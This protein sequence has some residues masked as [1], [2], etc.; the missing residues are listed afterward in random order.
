MESLVLQ[1]IDHCKRIAPIM[2]RLEIEPDGWIRSDSDTILLGWINVNGEKS[3]PTYRQDKLELALPEWL[4]KNEFQHLNKLKDMSH[5][6]DLI[7]KV[8]KF[9]RGEPKRIATAELI[10]L[11]EQEELGRESL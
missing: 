7:G 2:E 11:L 8:Y 3:V 10:E 1:S 9:H 5:G 6:L 4:Y